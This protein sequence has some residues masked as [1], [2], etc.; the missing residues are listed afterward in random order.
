MKYLIRLGLLLLVGILVYNYFFGTTQEKETSKKI[1]TEVK[2][3]SKATWDLFKSEKSKYDEGKYDGA[4]DKIGNVFNTL[5][6]KALAIKDSKVLD[7]LAELEQRRKELENR[8]N[9]DAKTQE[10]PSTYGSDGEI[11]SETLKRDLRK[12]MEETEAVMKE[13]ENK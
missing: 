4:L 5:K 11:E 8:L 1:F 7:K 13:L 10:K 3:L 9:E 2:D 12:L 6:D